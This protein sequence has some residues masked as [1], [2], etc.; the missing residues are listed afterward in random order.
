[1]TRYS[2]LA[3]GTAPTGRGGRLGQLRKP[4]TVE[5]EEIA[6]RLSVELL[7]CYAIEGARS[8]SR[9]TTELRTL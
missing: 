3:T 1:M 8:E 4:P 9:I 6:V 7:F 5:R 2:T